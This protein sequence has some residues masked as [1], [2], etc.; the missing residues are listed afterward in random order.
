MEESF[1][2]GEFMEFPSSRSSV[3][4]DAHGNLFNSPS[5]MHEVLSAGNTGLW[6]IVL[7][8]A[9]GEGQMMANDTM[10]RLLGLPRHPSATECYNH[11]FTRISPDSVS[12][13]LQVVESM[14]SSGQQGEVEYPWH[15][16]QWGWIYVRCGGKPSAAPEGDSRI[17]LRGYHQDISE[18]QAVRQSLQDN[19]SRL[20]TA[21]RIGN[22]GVFELRVEKNTF[23]LTANRIFAE[24]FG[25]DVGRPVDELLPILRS[26]IEAYDPA[27]WTPLEDV[28]RWEPGRRVRGEF[29]Y[30][31]PTSG[32]TRYVVEWEY[33]GQ[34]D[35]LHTVGFT[36][37]V[38]QARRYEQSLREAKENAEAANR[39]KSTFLANMSHEIRTP[40]NGVIGMCTLLQRTELTPG[41]RESMEKLDAMAHSMLGVLNDILD[42]SKIEAD[43][44]TLEQAPFCLGQTLDIVRSMVLT[45]AEEKGLAFHLEQSPDL[46]GGLLGDA[47]RL[48]QILLN[49]CDNAVKF[50]SRGTVELHVS[51][52]ERGGNTVRLAFVVRD[53][54]IGMSK[55]VMDRL[56]QPFTQADASTTRMFGGTGLGLAISRRLALMMGGDITV[57]SQEGEGS[58]FRLELPFPLSD[59]LCQPREHPA[60]EGQTDVRGLR[61]LVAEDNAINQEIIVSLLDC[62][63][64][65]SVVAGNGREAVDLFARDDTFDGI[66]MDVQMPL[67][68]G[69]AATE[70]IRRS[71]SP[72]AASVPIV[73]LTA[74]AM[75]GDAEKSRAAGMNGHLTKP[76]ELDDLAQTLAGWKK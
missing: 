38:T 72:R 7:D 20:E 73:A 30:R 6:T 56:F 24:Q 27:L 4:T 59:I 2:W 16:P 14:I 69:Y 1:L 55:A 44:L 53:Q 39:A 57:A 5:W 22:L 54:G 21:C 45:R 41:Q 28:R 76:V 66:L 23:V 58:V 70:R 71:P 25:V 46:P 33:V 75:R 47:L 49:L 19:L 60:G 36:R 74:H 51:V 63:G 26:R 34:G 35:K 17:Y 40:M 61:V 15:H 65:K 37:D 11:W 50:T 32:N 67:M 18:L 13:V 8:P 31:H 3:A 42:F 48:R 29:G 52:L 12:T 68:D 43:R 64:V 10:L 62:L 9:T